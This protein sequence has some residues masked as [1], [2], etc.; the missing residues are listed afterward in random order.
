MCRDVV[1]RCFDLRIRVRHGTHC[2][3]SCTTGTSMEGRTR[4]ELY[5]IA[6]A[7]PRWTDAW[8]RRQLQTVA[9]FYQVT[10]PL[11]RA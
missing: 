3:C 5:G 6:A 7:A 8:R 11:K 2:R 9:S 4:G 1:F 10:L